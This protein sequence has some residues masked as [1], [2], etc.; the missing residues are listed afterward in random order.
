MEE[1]LEIKEHKSCVWKVKWSDFRI[2]NLLA[3][4]SF[5]GT[6]KIWKITKCPKEQRYQYEILNSYEGTS[7]VNSIDW[8]PLYLGSKIAGCDSE[9]SV[10]I[11][12]KQGSSWKK[13][14]QKI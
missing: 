6:I 4:C 5:D 11:L 13:K 1:I 9:G 12:S 2:G 10:I 8:S 3:T 7:S 14:V